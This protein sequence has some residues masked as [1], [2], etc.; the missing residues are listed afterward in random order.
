MDDPRTGCDAKRDDSARPD[1]KP[2]KPKP[3]EDEPDLEGLGQAGTS[4]PVPGIAEDQGG[5]IPGAIGGGQSGQG[6]G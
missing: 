2:R 5:G 6:G 1:D 4:E 3:A